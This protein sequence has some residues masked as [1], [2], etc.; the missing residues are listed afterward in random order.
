MKKYFNKDIVMTKE[1]KNDFK[2][3][4]KFWICDNDYMRSLPYYWKIQRLSTWR[5]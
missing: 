2:N 3:S 1:D 5:L 4:T